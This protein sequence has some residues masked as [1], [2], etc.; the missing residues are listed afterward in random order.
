MEE[1]RSIPVSAS[2]Q[3]INSGLADR[4]FDR[5]LLAPVTDHTFAVYADVHGRLWMAATRAGGVQ[6]SLLH[7][8]AEPSSFDQAGLDEAEWGFLNSLAE[9]PESEQS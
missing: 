7:N 8:P 2:E 1:K 3:I 6:F 9:P 4:I 5:A